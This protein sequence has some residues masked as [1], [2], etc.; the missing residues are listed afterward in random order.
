MQGGPAF[1]LLDLCGQLGCV[2]CALCLYFEVDLI[3]AGAKEAQGLQGCRDVDLGLR[4]AVST[5][6]VTQWEY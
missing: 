5:H 6:Q 1:R 3:P 4:P 2:C